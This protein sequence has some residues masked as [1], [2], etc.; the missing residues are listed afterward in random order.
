MEFAF[1]LNAEQME[2]KTRSFCNFVHTIDEGDHTNAVVNAVCDYLSRKTRE[3]LTEKE[4]DKYNILY[5][6]IT[7]SLIIALTVNTS[8]DP[9]FTGQ[10][11]EKIENSQIVKPLKEIVKSQL[12]VYFTNNPK[13]L[14]TFTN[15]IKANAKARYEANKSRN[16]IIKREV[17]VISE[18]LI[19]NYFPA[20]NKGKKD[21]R[22]LFIF[23]GL[24]VK[25][26]GTQARDADY[27]AMYTMRGVPGELYSAKTSEIDK[28][29]TFK[30]LTR[31]INGGVGES[32]DVNKSRF[33]KVIITSDGDVDG[34][35]IFSLLG[36]FFLKHMTDLILDGRLYLSVPPLYK[37]KDSKTPFVTDK[38]QYQAVYFRRIIDKYQLKE[39]KG[40]ILNRK[41][42]LE[43]LNINKYYV[44]EL[45]R[46]KDHYSANPKLIEYIVK[47]KDDKNFKKNMKKLFPE[48]NIEYDRNNKKDMIIEG[49]Y[50]GAY[51]IFTVDEQFEKKTEKLRDLMDKNNEQYYYV[52][53]DYKGKNAMDRGYISIGEFLQSTIKLQ[54]SIELRYK[55]LGELDENDMWMTVMNPETR[56][57]IQLT[58]DDVE[59]ACQTYDTLHGKGKVN[60]ENRREMTDSFEIN[61]EMLDN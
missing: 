25:S 13:D 24:S 29:E 31:A 39:K 4:K 56:T 59:K 38:E 23:E 26:N 8:L 28:N 18:H 61:M 16:S 5:N 17:S 55:G 21:Y 45:T 34:F 22:E 6:D 40:K 1:A 57:L 53:E 54:P 35:F 36:G 41:E 14:K 15:V 37:I 46:C 47:Y 12:N 33:D 43:F 7:N 11:K 50:E 51:Q 52:I 2:M 60:A 10:T 3:I 30:N 58:V 44:D 48:I 32:F 27:Q 42:M 20:N 49:V 19:P 9:G